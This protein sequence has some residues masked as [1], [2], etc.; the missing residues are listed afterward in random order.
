MLHV[1]LPPQLCS[2][3]SFNLEFLPPSFFL[4]PTYSA[5]KILLQCLFLE[6]VQDGIQTSQ[7][8]PPLNSYSTQCVD[9]LSGIQPVLNFSLPTFACTHP[10]S[11]IDVPSRTLSASLLLPFSYTSDLQFQVPVALLRLQF[12]HGK[13][14]TLYHSP[15]KTFSDNYTSFTDSCIYLLT[16]YLFMQQIFVHTMGQALEVPW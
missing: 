14:Q 4:R 15:L 7:T 1:S 11:P 12:Q 3:S 9:Q 16:K 8:P 2:Q 5:F 13:N 10:E 6:M